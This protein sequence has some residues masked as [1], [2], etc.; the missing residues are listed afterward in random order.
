MPKRSTVPAT[1]QPFLA[2]HGDGTDPWFVLWANELIVMNKQ[3]RQRMQV[4]SKMLDMGTILALVALA[5]VA[6]GLTLAM[7][8]LDPEKIKSSAMSGRGRRSEQ[9]RR[10]LPH[11]TNAHWTL[12]TL[13]ILNAIAVE[14]M[15]LVLSRLYGGI[16]AVMLSVVL[17]LFFGEIIPQ[18]LFTRYALPV[19]SFF[20]PFRGGFTFWGV[21][22]TL[23]GGG[24]RN[25]R[26]EGK[27]K[28]KISLLCFVSTFLVLHMCPVDVCVF[29]SAPLPT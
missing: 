18:A 13:L 23:P 8:T 2:V 26:W 7:F 22:G 24:P 21:F 25:P 19:C 5:G 20:S 16:I 3:N 11:L 14:T 12:V 9:A 17:V 4:M 6:S 10:V 1:Y 27:K 29:V 28:K 15:P